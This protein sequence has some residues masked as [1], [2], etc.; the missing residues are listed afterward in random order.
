M[1]RCKL[2]MKCI[3]RI[4]MYLV[5]VLDTKNASQRSRQICSAFVYEPNTA[6]INTCHMLI[7]NIHIHRHL[8][9]NPRIL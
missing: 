5:C 9:R 2:Q 4:W 8:R 3:C 6:C 1:R 7:L